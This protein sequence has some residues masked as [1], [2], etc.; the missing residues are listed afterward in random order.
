M[1]GH[2]IT[3]N[4]D[5]Q[6]DTHR[7]FIG[8]IVSIVVKVLMTIY[9]LMKLG[10]LVFKDGSNNAVTALMVKLDLLG[11]VEYFD[12]NLLLFY[13]LKKQKTRG[14]INLDQPDLDRYIDIYMEQEQTN[15]YLTEE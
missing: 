11:E 2:P 6:G 1:F 4:F 3:L 10:K 9:I 13:V 14:T 5:K 12:T 7:T 8:G 15:W